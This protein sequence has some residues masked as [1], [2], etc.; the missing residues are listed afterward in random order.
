MEPSENNAEEIAA[1]YAAI[2]AS[3]QDAIIG[4]DLRGVVTSWNPAAEYIFGYQASEIIGH[5]IE[6]LIPPERHWEEEMILER[7][8]RGERVPIFETVRLCKDGSTRDV[9][10]TVAPVMDARGRI[11]G[12][13]KLVRDISEHKRAEE[14][15][16]QERGLLRM[17]IDLLP[18]HIYVKDFESRFVLANSGVAQVMLGTLKPELLIGKFDG[19]FYPQ[20]EAAEF[21]SDELAVL[22]GH[23][24]YDKEEPL[25]HPDGTRRFIITTKVP[26]KDTDGNII[27]L[28]GIGRDITARKLAEEALR[29]SEERFRTI[30]ENS[31]LGIIFTDTN[32]D[33]NYANEAQ[34]RICGGAWEELAGQGWQATIHPDDRERVI[35]EWQ[36]VGR[37][38]QP[39][40]SER[41]YLHK[42]GNIVWASM[43][44]A[45]IRDNAG[46]RGYVGIVE[47]ITERKQAETRIR[48]LNQELESRVI[49]RTAELRTAVDA[50]ETEITERQRLEREILE[51]SEREKARVGQDLHDGLCQTLAGIGCL[52]RVLQRNLDEENLTPDAVSAKAESIVNLLKEATNEARGLAAGMYP[53][54]IEEYGLAPGLEKLADDTAE[55]FHVACKFECAEPIVLADNDVAKHVYRITQ[56][57]VSNAI[58]HGKAES[59]VITLA[60]IDNQVTLKIEDNGEGVLTEFEP[61]GMGLKTMNYRAHAIGGSLEIRQRPEHGI[62]VICSFPNRPGPE[63]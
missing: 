33:T 43:T 11:I 54:N 34:Q 15:L 3:S 28:V 38:G 13:S 41:R 60:A 12:A 8:Q 32:S 55:R 18:D 31:P 4:K 39:F 30:C 26:L 7:I 6:R 24:L 23:A 36:E 52:A 1:R 44:A 47:D 61:T 45:P 51:I 58:A 5:S 25:T 56:E 40:R 14:A 17:V 49:E 19:D 53:V 22:N 62:E 35:R 59:V 46:I 27:G 57:A 16:E 48:I 42:D 50:L 10:V 29:E 2:V 20:N 63:A 37:T 21:R 9:S